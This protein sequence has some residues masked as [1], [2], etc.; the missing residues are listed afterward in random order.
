MIKFIQ[1][2]MCRLGLHDDGTDCFG[3]YSPT[4]LRCGRPT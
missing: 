4:C 1:R 3:G 2:I